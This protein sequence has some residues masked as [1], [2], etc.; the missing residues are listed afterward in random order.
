MPT[1]L[2]ESDLALH[3]TPC[4]QRL[5]KG[6]SDRCTCNGI[7]TTLPTPTGRAKALAS[8][9]RQAITTS[10]RG[11]TDSKGP[12]IIARCDAKRISVQCDDA[13]DIGENHAAAAL[14]LMRVLGWDER[15]ELAM[16]GTRDGFVFV[17]VPKNR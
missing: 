3:E 13:L 11:P 14:E 2:T 5:R 6:D 12:R 7:A 8:Y 1:K 4:A 10:Y 17:Q 16:G 9:H 15:N